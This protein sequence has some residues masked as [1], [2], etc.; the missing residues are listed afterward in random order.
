MAARIVLAIAAI[1]VVVLGSKVTRTATSSA[2]G[3]HPGD[4]VIVQGTTAR[5]GTI[6]ASR[7]TAS[8]AGASALPAGGGFFARNGP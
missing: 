6:T 4:T 7:V 5:D 3:V 8:Q 1:A 2:R